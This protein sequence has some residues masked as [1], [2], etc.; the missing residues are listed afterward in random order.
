MWKIFREEQVFFCLSYYNAS[1]LT[2][3]PHKLPTWFSV[4]SFLFYATVIFCKPSHDIVIVRP[5]STSY[6]SIEWEK[7]ISLAGTFFA[8]L[9]SPG[10]RSHCAMATAL[11]ELSHLAF[12]TSLLSSTV[13]V[14]DNIPPNPHSNH[15]LCVFSK[16]SRAV[17]R[18]PS[19]NL[20]S[21]SN[22][23]FI[24]KM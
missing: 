10:A 1:R 3:L 5:Q 19:T 17:V 6:P 4:E 12:R 16:L 21:D 20:F 14:S 2:T 13:Y 8:S 15:S 11:C 9:N 23:A 7:K 18:R 24:L 22:S